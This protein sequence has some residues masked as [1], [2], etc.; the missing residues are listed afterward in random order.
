MCAVPVNKS[1]AVASASRAPLTDLLISIRRLTDVSVVRLNSTQRP[2]RFNE[3]QSSPLNRHVVRAAAAHTTVGAVEH[4]TSTISKS[5]GVAGAAAG[6]ACASGLQRLSDW[7]V[8]PGEVPCDA[9]LLMHTSQ[10][11]VWLRHT[12]RESVWA[13]LAAPA[14]SKSKESLAAGGA[15]IAAD[16]PRMQGKPSVLRTSLR[17]S[18]AVPVCVRVKA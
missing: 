13:N 8:P 18:V 7:C 14:P 15:A 4:E 5:T 1:P 9:S 12:L 2:S 11:A 17:R 16:G 3:M 6:A 10:S